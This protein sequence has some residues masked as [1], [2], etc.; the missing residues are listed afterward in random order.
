M[1]GGHETPVLD[2]ETPVLDPVLDPCAADMKRLSSIPADM[3]RLSSIRVLDPADMK[4]LSSI[5]ADMKR[6]SSI[7][8]ETPVLDPSSIPVRRT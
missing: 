1:C 8:H 7:R 2:S 6:L 3:K 5:P 4:R